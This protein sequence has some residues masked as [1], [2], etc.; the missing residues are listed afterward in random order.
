[1]KFNK[2]KIIKF[3]H[4]TIFFGGLNLFLISCSNLKTFTKILKEKS[5][6]GTHINF[7]LVPPQIIKEYFESF[8]ILYKAG[9]FYKLLLVPD[10]K[11]RL[12]EVQSIDFDHDVNQQS[13]RFRYLSD[14]VKA[15][16]FYEVAMYLSSVKIGEINHQLLNLKNDELLVMDLSKKWVEFDFNKK[17][18]Y[19]P[20][21]FDENGDFIIQYK[22]RAKNTN[23]INNYYTKI[24]INKQK[25][26]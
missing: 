23:Q 18:Q 20:T 24:Q 7:S 1:M 5:T 4:I 26:D 13:F 10:Q 25:Q 17:D 2:N 6:E 11:T 22:I 19:L 9:F 3:L 15:E 16:K 14:I 12:I 8:K 21:K